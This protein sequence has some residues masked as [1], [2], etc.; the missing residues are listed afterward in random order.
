MMIIAVLTLLPLAVVAGQTDSPSDP[1]STAG[2]MPTLEELYQYLTSGMAPEAAEPFQEPTAGPGS[3]MYTLQ[4]IYDAIRD[5]FD[6]CAITPDKVLDN[7]QQFFNTTGT[8]GPAAGTM[9]NNGAVTITPGASAQ[10][11][12]AGYHNGSGSV[13]GDTDLTPEN[14]VAGVTIFGVTGTAPTLDPDPNLTPE[15]IACG[16]TVYG[17]TGTIGSR[18][19]DNGDGTVTDLTTGMM[20]TLRAN[21]RQMGWDDAIQYCNDLHYVGYDD[22]RLPTRDELATLVD[23]RF[24]FPALSNACGTGKWTQGD[25]FTGVRSSRYWSSTPHTSLSDGAWYVHLSD[26]EENYWHKSNRTYVWPVRSGQ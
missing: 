17:V 12:D 2:H 25:A 4:A 11:I 7:G 14:I 22:W 18:F 13:Q 6:Q 1:A 10:S 5:L 19:R 8:W 20:W 9:P 24:R 26:G 21:L 3:T 23:S 16:V 15:N